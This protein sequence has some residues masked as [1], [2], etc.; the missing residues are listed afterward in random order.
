MAQKWNKLII[1]AY[2]I[3][4]LTSKLVNQVEARL[5]N[6]GIEFEINFV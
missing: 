1:E 3:I 5:Y 4:Q 6:Q 2:P